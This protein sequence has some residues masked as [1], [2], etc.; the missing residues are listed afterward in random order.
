MILRICHATEAATGQNAWPAF[1]RTQQ[2]GTFA[3]CVSQPAHAALSAQIGQALDPASFGPLPPEV[4]DAIHHHDA[5]WGGPDL[6]AIECIGERQPQSFLAYPAAGAVNV[7]RRSIRE[8]EARSPLAGIL[9]SR[10][11]CL[12]APRDNDPHHAA[13]VEQENQRRA[14]HEAASSLSREDLDRYTSALG[15]CDLLSLCLCS[16]LIG[17]VQIPLGHPAD[18]ASQGAR[19][20]KVSLAG[21]TA[22]FNQQIMATDTLIHVDGWVPF[23]PNVLASQR[24]YW[25]VG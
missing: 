19:K 9:T 15:F 1:T 18:P 17:S 21:E 20:V 11:F 8:A 4:I 25:T 12:L 6:A 5:G 22:R 13:F 16:G 24:F 10:H 7:W 3:G 14:P 23:A 2:P